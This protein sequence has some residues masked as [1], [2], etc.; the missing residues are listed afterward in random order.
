MTYINCLFLPV[1]KCLG[2]NYFHGE[3]VP[4]Q[5]AAIPGMSA[6]RGCRK[7]PG[8]CFGPFHGSHGGRGWKRANSSPIPAPTPSDGVS[9]RLNSVTPGTVC[10]Y[11]CRNNVY[12]SQNRHFL[13]AVHLKVKLI[14]PIF[15]THILTLLMCVLN[16]RSQI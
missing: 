1:T 8:L 5:F 7:C 13:K 6:Q 16:R 3:Q 4:Q 11:I 12:V 14:E 9:E 10:T 15:S 2:A